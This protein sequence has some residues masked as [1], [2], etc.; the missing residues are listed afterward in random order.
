MLSR[1]IYHTEEQLLDLIE[2]H[3]AKREPVTTITLS[4]LVGS[5]IAAG[6]GTGTMVL[7]QQRQHYFTLRTSLDN[8]L[9]R[10]EDCITLLEDSLSSLTEAAPQNHRG[11]DLLFLQQSGLCAALREECCFYRDY[12]GHIKVNMAKIRERLERRRE[13]EAQQA[14]FES[15]FNNSPWLTTFMS[16]ITEPLVVLLLLLTFG[17]CILNRLIQFTKNRLGTIQ[18]MVQ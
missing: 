5:D 15:W 13:R 12:S 11:L 18:L 3:K 17:P 6:I 14:W 4:L 2:N 16:T 8:G 9:K 7:I 1:L 10:I